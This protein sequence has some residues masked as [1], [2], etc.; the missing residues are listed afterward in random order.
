MNCMF[1]NF[2]WNIVWN[3]FKWGS[4]FHQRVCR[5]REPY[6]LSAG[7]T[8]IFSIWVFGAVDGGGGICSDRY[9]LTWNLSFSV[10][11]LVKKTIWRV[12]LF[13]NSFLLLNKYRQRQKL[14]VAHIK[15]WLTSQ[16]PSK[17]HT[18]IS[19]FWVISSM[20][21]FPSLSVIITVRAGIHLRP[22]ENYN[23]IST[24]KR[25]CLFESLFASVPCGIR[26]D[27]GN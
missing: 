5:L 6:S 15:W 1:I 18:K 9:I 21:S 20:K 8:T 17:K 14:C 27:Q 11:V 12:L 19:K 10:I 4:K 3:T 16:N 22:Q 7:T 2:M 13:L 24:G 23:S 26:R 25:K